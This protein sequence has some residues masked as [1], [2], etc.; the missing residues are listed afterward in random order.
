MTK[1]LTYV[2][3]VF[4]IIGIPISTIYWW[5]QFWGPQ[6]GYWDQ[7]VPWL[8]IASAILGALWILRLV[9]WIKEKREESKFYREKVRAMNIPTPENTSSRG[10]DWFV[11][12]HGQAS[13][14]PES[15]PQGEPITFVDHSEFINSKSPFAD[16]LTNQRINCLLEEGEIIIKEAESIRRQTGNMDFLERESFLSAINHK[17]GTERQ[18]HDSLS[19]SIRKK[20][21]IGRNKFRL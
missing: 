3:A 1:L 12:E 15:E 4:L 17:P 8:K 11:N 2:T 19:D 20:Y 13:R 14:R 5:P 10:P 7:W 6:A 21:G 9:I 18:K 16:F